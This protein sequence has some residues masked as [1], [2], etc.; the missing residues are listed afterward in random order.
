MNSKRFLIQLRYLGFRYH[1][2]QKQ[3]GLQS[4]QGRVEE[5]LKK[6]LKEMPLQTRFSSRT[7]ALVSSLESY[8]LLMCE[9]EA[10]LEMIEHALAKLPPDIEVLSVKKVADDYILL[11][12]SGEKEYHY[13]FC[14]NQKNFHPF[15]SAFM[16]HIREELDIEL[17]KKG[18]ALFSGEHD[19]KNYAHKLK[20]SVD[21]R[22]KIVSSTLERNEVLVASFFPVPSYVFKVRGAGFMRGQVRAMMGALF[23]LG[24]GELTL[25]ELKRSLEQ[26]DATF[27]KWLAP[28]SGLILQSTEIK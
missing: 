9:K 3:P 21:S 5:T 1:G 17:M 12:H 22:R 23:R 10:A 19:F 14:F 4:V 7:D 6:S 26:E 24:K 11:K 2:V 16:T 27:V 20:D 18:A 13:Y 28:S 8:C 15:S 25:P